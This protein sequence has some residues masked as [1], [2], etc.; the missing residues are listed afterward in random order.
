[1]RILLADH[2]SP[3]LSALQTRLREEASLIVVGAVS[4]AESLITEVQELQPD[5]ILLDWELPGKD[6]QDLIASLHRIEP[7]PIVIAMSSKLEKGRA[8]L[9]A[10]ADAFVSKREDSTWLI[11]TLQILK[12]QTEGSKK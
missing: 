1:M 7:R 11:E 3:V 8:A 9:A 2:H 10:G 4:S 6:S 12:S 5:L